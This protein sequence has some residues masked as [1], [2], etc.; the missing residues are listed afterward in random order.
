M[1]NKNHYL[2][3]PISSAV[4]SAVV[5][6]LLISGLVYFYSRLW[7]LNDPGRGLILALC[8]ILISDGVYLLIHANLRTKSKLQ[9]VFFSPEKLSVVL[10]S[11]NGAS[12]ITRTINEAHMHVPLNQIIV[13][14]DKSTDDT[15]IL[16]KKVGA[17]VYENE[18]NLNKA[19]TIS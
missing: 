18:I 5:I 8:F 2:I 11:H 15:V 7:F 9:K 6:S 1:R 13:V 4:S 17:T 16:A 19:L 3:S 12:A 10:S 14:S